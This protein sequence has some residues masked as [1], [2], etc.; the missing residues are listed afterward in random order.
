MQCGFHDD[1]FFYRIFRRHTGM[2]P[3]QY[4]RTMYS[5]F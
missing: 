1:L 3:M 2:S 4:R 5:G